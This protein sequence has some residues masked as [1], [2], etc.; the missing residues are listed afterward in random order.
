MPLT[1]TGK[2]VK[3]AMKK[4]YGAKKGTDVF[5]GYETKNKNNKK[6]KELMKANRGSM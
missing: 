5:Y 3:A 6:G 1:K 2:K 4:E